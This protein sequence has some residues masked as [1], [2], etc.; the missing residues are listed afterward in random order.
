MVAALTLLAA[1]VLPTAALA[2]TSGPS[3]GSITVVQVAPTFVYTTNTSEAMEVYS[4][5]DLTIPVTTMTPQVEYYVKAVVGDANTL[6]DLS[7]VEV[8]LKYYAGGSTGSGDIHTDTGS[9]Q[10]EIVLTCSDAGSGSPTWTFDGGSGSSGSIVS[11]DCSQPTTSATSGTYKFAF[12]PGKVASQSAGGV[13]ANAGFALYGYVENSGTEA[14]SIWYSDASSNVKK[15]IN[16]YGETAVNSSTVT[17]TDMAPGTD[18]GGTGSAKT[19]LSVDY[20]SNGYL[21][22]GDGFY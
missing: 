18:F 5:A 3:A 15:G 4:D 1:I 10:T 13:L 19:D 2:A 7:T 6:A 16:W 21:P 11:L 14:A 22:Y 17:W 20:V 8:I 9:T 12:I